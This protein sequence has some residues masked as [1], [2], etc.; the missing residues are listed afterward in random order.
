MLTLIPTPIGNLDDITHRALQTLK[1]VDVLLVEDTRI[2]GKLLHHFSIKKTMIPFHA[3]NEHAKL[4]EIIN[5]LTTGVHIGLVS[6]AGTPG[7]SDPGFLLVR[8]CRRKNIPVECLPGPTAF[9]PALAVSGL[10]CDTFYFQGF[11]PRKKGR[12]TTLE[13][14]QQLDTTIILYESPYR[15]VKTLGDIATYFGDREISVSREISKRFEETRNGT[16]AE[17]QQYFEE[18]KPKGEF[19]ICV[20]KNS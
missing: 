14:L 8:E 2:T 1:K 15:V 7:I 5:E 11:L 3:H 17:L 20:G 13:Q 18:H 10:P 12:K 9:V 19:V 4:D 6:D 16:A